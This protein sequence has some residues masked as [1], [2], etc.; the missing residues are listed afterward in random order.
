[1]NSTLRNG[2]KKVE[3]TLIL[4]EACM[5][6]TFFFTPYVFAF[7]FKLMTSDFIVNSVLQKKVVLLSNDHLDRNGRFGQGLLIQI[8]IGL[9]H[10]HVG[11]GLDLMGEN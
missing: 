9:Q 4:L 6:E 1:M 10:F 7:I 5:N 8:T 11:K 3:T 2:P